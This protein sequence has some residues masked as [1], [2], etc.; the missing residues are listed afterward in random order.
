MAARSARVSPLS[1]VAG[2]GVGFTMSLGAGVAGIGLVFPSTSRQ[3]LTWIAIA[4]AGNQHFNT[5]E[6]E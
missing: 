5:P 1:M 3:S 2:L 4:Y 6:R